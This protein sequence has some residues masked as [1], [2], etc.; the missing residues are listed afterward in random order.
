MIKKVVFAFLF[1][2]LCYLAFHFS[3]LKYGISQGIG[4]AKVLMN[5]VSIES[6]KNNPNT[7]D[8]ILQ[9]IAFIEEVKTYAYDSIGL[10]ET[11]NYTSFY[12]QKGKPILWVVTASPEFQIEAHQW[13]F[14]IAGCF[15]YKGFFEYEKALAEE[16]ELKTKGFDTDIG[17]V[18]AWSTLGFFKDPILSSMLN[19]SEGSLAELIIHELTHATLYVKNDVSFNENLANFVGKQGAI[20]FLKHKYS[21][22]SLE[23]FTYQNSLLKKQVFA[24]YMRNQLK[25]LKQFYD[26]LNISLSIAK[27]RQL[28]EQQLDQIKWGLLASSYFKDST[29]AQKRLAKFQPNNAFFTGFS[30][31]SKQQTDFHEILK[32]EHQGRLKDFIIAFK[33]IHGSG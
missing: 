6:V 7:P 30:T 21:D 26:T 17:E 2:L 29:E 1:L 14:P 15:P 10:S 19:R 12:N 9:K 18:S 31:Y 24:D 3:A 22:T 25:T 8:S 28:K 32:N 23:V 33:K 27:K 4:Q 5:T 20:E 13:C 16:Q 11:D